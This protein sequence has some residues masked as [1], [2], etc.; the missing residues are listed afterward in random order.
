MSSKHPQ[1][2]V[3]PADGRAYPLDAFL[4]FYGED[5]GQRRWATAGQQ[6]AYPGVSHCMCDLMAFV[7]LSTYLSISLFLLRLASV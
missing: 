2:R 6:P 1:Q 7:C 4:E 3:D 5:E